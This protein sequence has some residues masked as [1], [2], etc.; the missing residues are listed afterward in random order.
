MGW[1]FEYEMTGRSNVWVRV[2]S[3]TSVMRKIP[4]WG[5]KK[6]E[7]SSKI[8]KSELKIEKK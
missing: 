4:F 5:P 1:F 8:Q 7:E 6:K 2:S 3:G